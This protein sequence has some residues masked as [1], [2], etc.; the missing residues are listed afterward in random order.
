MNAI[1]AVTTLESVLTKPS[2][3]FSFNHPVPLKPSWAVTFGH[4]PG[5]VL[6]ELNG[7]GVTNFVPK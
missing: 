5:L 1:K 4:S 2:L 6:I 7:S 3:P